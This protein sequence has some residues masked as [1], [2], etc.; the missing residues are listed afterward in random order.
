MVTVKDPRIGGL[1]ST[2]LTGKIT[3]TTDA[4]RRTINFRPNARQA[5]I[6]AE[7][8]AMRVGFTSR[9]AAMYWYDDSAKV[10]EQ[11]KDLLGEDKAMLDST[12]TG[13]TRATLA[14]ADYLY[15]GTVKEVGGFD[16][17]LTTPFNNNGSAALTVEYSTSNNF[18][19]NAV[20]DGTDTGST[21]PFGQDGNITWNPIPGAGLWSSVMLNKIISGAPL[22]GH[23]PLYWTR[24][25]PLALLD[26]I[27]FA[28]VKTMLPIVAAGLADSD[29]SQAKKGVEYVLTL[30][31]SKNGSIEAWST[32]AGDSDLRITWVT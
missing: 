30:D 28:Q 2:T 6:E 13:I 12:K 3:P 9:I 25:T 15:I 19:S 1:P 14:A 29:G 31:R 32:T 8:Q 4:N 7:D 27:T 20:T 24:M 10:G 17:D 26:I 23:V 21:T 16:F 22:H 11:F 5:L 18:V